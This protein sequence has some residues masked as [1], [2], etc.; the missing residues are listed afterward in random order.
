LSLLEVEVWSCQLDH[1]SPSP[2]IP[3]PV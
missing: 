1:L 2:G 3:M